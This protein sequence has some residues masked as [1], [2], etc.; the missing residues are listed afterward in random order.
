MA[1][2]AAM[3]KDAGLLKNAVDEDIAIMPEEKEKA[4]SALAEIIDSH[5]DI[6]RWK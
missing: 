5:N 3:N 1:V 2:K 4:K 6:L